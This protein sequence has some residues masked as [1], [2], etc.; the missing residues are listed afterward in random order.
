MLEPFAH[1][2]LRLQLGSDWGCPLG[3]GEGGNACVSHVRERVGPP[4]ESSRPPYGMSPGP[5]AQAALLY[6]L[7]HRFGAWGFQEPR[8]FESPPGRYKGG[9]MTDLAIFIPFRFL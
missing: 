4:G 8:I 3:S 2:D 5:R 7:G 1:G 9:A 6:P